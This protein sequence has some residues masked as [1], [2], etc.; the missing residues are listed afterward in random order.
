MKA[1]EVPLSHRRPRAAHDPC[2][3]GV[4]CNNAPNDGDAL[5]PRPIQRLL[6]WDHFGI[7]YVRIAAIYHVLRTF[8]ALAGTAEYWLVA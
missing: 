5:A 2:D 1:A 8:D 3:D 6:Q 4:F 7:S